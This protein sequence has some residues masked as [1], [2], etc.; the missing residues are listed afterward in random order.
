[1][2]RRAHGRRDVV[3]EIAINMLSPKELEYLLEENEKLRNHV[4]ELVE[5]LGSPGGNNFGLCRSCE[6]KRCWLAA[7]IGLALAGA[8][9]SAFIR[10]MA[11]AS[12]VV[13]ITGA[14]GWTRGVIAELT[15]QAHGYL[16]AQGW[17]RAVEERVYWTVLGALILG[18]V[19]SV[20]I[21][22][23]LALFKRSETWKRW[24][25]YYAWQAYKQ[26]GRE[27]E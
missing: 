19:I 9:A 25:I 16:S 12:H 8:W 14:Y 22:W 17:S 27:R 18:P 24:R 1:M 4:A 11:P 20:V 21:R 10:E 23:K 13:W 3:R 26:A 6:I 7:L 15:K 5:Q 2:E